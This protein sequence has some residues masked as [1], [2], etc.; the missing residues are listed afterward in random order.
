MCTHVD[1]VGPYSNVMFV[2]NSLHEM[3]HIHHYDISTGVR[4]D[5]CPKFIDFT[6]IIFPEIL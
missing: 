1:I 2:C 6:A 4:Y 3:N 5:N